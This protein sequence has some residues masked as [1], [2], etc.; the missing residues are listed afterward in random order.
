MGGV[1][2]N[3]GGRLES[4]SRVDMKDDLFQ[5]NIAITEARVNKGSKMGVL[6]EYAGLEETMEHG[7]MAIGVGRHKHREIIVDRGAGGETARSTMIF[8]EA[9]EGMNIKALAVTGAHH[10][11][12]PGANGTW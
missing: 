5:G 10:I 3:P 4:K 7:S 8:T 1:L 9:P 6:G 2:S 12:I 11:I